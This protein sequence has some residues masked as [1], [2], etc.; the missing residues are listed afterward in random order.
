MYDNF[1]LDLGA[2]TSATGVQVVK[3]GVRVSELFLLDLPLG[4]TF[5][6]SI[7]DGPWITITKGFTME[8]TGAGFTDG[9][10][11]WR[12]LVAQAGVKLELVVFYNVEVN[13]V[14]L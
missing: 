13:T 9:G 8:P 7:A 10:I 1:I 11:R 2:V 6:F 3:R 12:N 4:A 5:Q 14:I